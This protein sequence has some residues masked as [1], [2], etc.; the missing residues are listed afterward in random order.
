MR[1]LMTTTL[2]CSFAKYK[3][4][5][6]LLG[7]M[8]EEPNL[9]AKELDKFRRYFNRTNS[10]LANKEHPNFANNPHDLVTIERNEVHPA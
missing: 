5:N 9:K 10:Y 2:R 8:G 6:H 1:R 4:A 3:E 7:E